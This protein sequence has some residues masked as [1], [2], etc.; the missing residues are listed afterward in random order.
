M[1]NKKHLPLYIALA[2]PILMILLVWAFIYLPSIGKSPRHNF[3]YVTGNNI[4]D[5]QRQYPIIGGHLTYNPTAYQPY[6]NPPT[7]VH[8]YL[9]DV[10][11]NESTE[12]TLGQAQSYTLDPSYTSDDGYTIQQG[13]GG[14][15]FP[16]GGA[17]RDY[18]SWFLKG[19]NRSQ[20]LNLKLTAGTQYYP[21]NF[22][23][24]GWIQ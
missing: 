6:Y 1:I 16:F 21:G 8:F 20:K 2:V 7:D 3:L 13:S 22:Q 14:S 17:T 12:I 18:N 9:Y 10:A 23:F 15:D 24:L 19:H 5:V 4:Y 11:K